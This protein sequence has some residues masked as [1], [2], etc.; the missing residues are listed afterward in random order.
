MAVASSRADRICTLCGVPYHA[1]SYRSH[2]RLRL[3][4]RFLKPKGSALTQAPYIRGPYDKDRY[5][6]MKELYDL[7]YSYQAIADAAG[8]TRQRVGQILKRAGVARGYR[9]GRT[10][11]VC[12]KTYTQWSAH[13]NDVWHAEETAS[14]IDQLRSRT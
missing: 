7:G 3:H 6:W 2:A 9:P 1:G 11:F 8:I 4:R 12:G 13:V 5:V 14:L 10:C